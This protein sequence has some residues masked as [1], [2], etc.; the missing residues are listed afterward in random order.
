M[1]AERT[2][3][4]PH[5]VATAVVFDWALTVQLTTQAVA[6]S[7]GHLGLVRDPLTIA[8]RLVAA[9]LL[10]ALGEGLRRGIAMLRLVEAAIVALVTVLGVVSA[11]LLITGHGG[12]GLVFSVI[13]ELTFAPW[14]AWALLNRETAAWFAAS[15]VQ[16]RPPAP[17]TS[18][19]RWMLVLVALSVA[20]GVAVA[21]SQSL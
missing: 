10:L 11:G 17:R 2:H 15:S 8:G 21:W 4:R 18:G 3:P 5:G 12:R 1:A 16:T 7:T 13:I 14:L 19:W 20:C 6:A 9:A